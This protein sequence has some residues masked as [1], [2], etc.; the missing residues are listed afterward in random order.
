MIGTTPS[1]TLNTVAIVSTAPAAPSRCPS[2]DF[3]A[4]TSAWSPMAA[5]IAIASATSPVGVEVA[6]AF[7]ETTSAGSSPAS[8]SASVIARAAPLPL[9][10]GAVMW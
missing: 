2:I 6:C 9:G 10:S 1:R 4:V 8:R 7:T 5:L 3:G